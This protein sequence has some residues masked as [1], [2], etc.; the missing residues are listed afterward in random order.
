[1]H[2]DIV[3]IT[4]THIHRDSSTILN[5]VLRGSEREMTRR[6]TH[7]RGRA[8]ASEQR[9]VRCHQIIYYNMYI[10]HL[11]NY[12]Y[13]AHILLRIVVT[14][15]LLQTNGDVSACACRVLR[16]CTH[17]HMHTH[18]RIACKHISPATQ[19]AVIHSK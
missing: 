11:L 13:T 2:E 15:P 4:H 7:I 19:H 18:I 17:R 8:R 3:E 6:H 9:T 16:H 1:M 12:T 14:E 5:N 10:K